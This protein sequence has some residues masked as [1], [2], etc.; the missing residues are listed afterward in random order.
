MSGPTENGF[1]ELTENPEFFELTQGLLADLPGGLLGLGGGD[2]IT[3]SS[4]SEII[5]GNRDND[6][7]SGGEG[8]D[9]LYGGKNMDLLYCHL[10]SV[11]NRQEVRNL[12]DHFQD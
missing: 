7:I 12:Q 9:T 11:P 1:Y 6:I 3:G 10:E 8:N 2:F 4:D 5:N